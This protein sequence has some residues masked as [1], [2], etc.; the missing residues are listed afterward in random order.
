M[1][2]LREKPYLAFMMLLLPLINF[3]SGI[4]IDLY[5]PSMPAIATY[6]HSSAA[7]IQNTVSISVIGWA[8]GGLLWGVLFDACGRKKIVLCMLFV[9]V[10]SS[11]WAIYCQ[12]VT[13]LMLIRFIQGF[14][15]A[16]MSIGCRVL[17]SDHF[18]GHQFNVALIY[19][20][21]SYALGT[22]IG[23]FVGGYLQYH[24]GWQANFGAFILVGLVFFI[25]ILI[26]VQER[27]NQ[28]ID[29]TIKDAVI[30]YK[31]V[32][33]NKVFFAGC[34][35]T[36]I[37]QIEMMFYPTFGSFIVENQLHYSPITF[38]NYAMII[39]VGYVVT[40]LINRMLLQTFS[41]NSLLLFGYSMLFLSIVLQI[42]FTLFLKINLWTLLLPLILIYAANGFIFGNVMPACLKLFPNNAGVATATQ[43]CMLMFIGAFGTFII[44][45]MDLVSLQRILLVFVVLVT[46]KFL[47]Y[48]CFFQKVFDFTSQ[49][50]T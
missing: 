5:A 11:I 45:L 10:A 6:F 22:I 47:A 9:F 25:M 36:G 2:T 26:F 39:S 24:F 21:L 38:G 1:I 8:V 12:S 34:V 40:S 43:V 41:Q 28:K 15:V 30:F 37:V 42:I 19:T 31:T 46:I 48:K 35:I 33:T 14:A 23:P 13:A 3:V 16:A 49:A 29:S 17:V 4:S 7:A 32:I 50:T 18:T 20:S 44:S 27:F